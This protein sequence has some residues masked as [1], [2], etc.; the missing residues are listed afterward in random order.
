MQKGRFY[1]LFGAKLGIAWGGLGNARMAA[2]PG[3]AWEAQGMQKGRF[4]DLFG[5]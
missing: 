5:A 1:D 3:E 4:Y 2:L